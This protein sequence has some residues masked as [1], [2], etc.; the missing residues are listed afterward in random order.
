M[1]IGDKASKNHDV[2]LVTQ[3]Y[4]QKKLVT[5]YVK[6]M[7]KSRDAKAKHTTPPANLRPPK[8]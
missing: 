3:K 1:R 2:E 4:E 7:G 6:A 8:E 5:R